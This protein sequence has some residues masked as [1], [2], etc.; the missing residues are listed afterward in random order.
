M[1]D[2]G[3]VSWKFYQMYS[4]EKYPKE[5]PLIKNRFPSTGNIKKPIMNVSIPENSFIV[6]KKESFQ[7]ENICESEG[8]SFDETIFFEKCAEKMIKEVT[9]KTRKTVLRN[10]KPQKNVWK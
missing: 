4:A 3:T 10:R 6:P 8:V 7:A 1:S 2:K 9:L 5:V